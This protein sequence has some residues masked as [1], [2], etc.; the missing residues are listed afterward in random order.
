MDRLRA[1][2][3][4]LMVILSGP[5]L[6]WGHGH[7]WSQATFLLCSAW[8]GAMIIKRAWRPKPVDPDWSPRNLPGIVYIW[9]R[10]RGV[11]YDAN[12]VSRPPDPGVYL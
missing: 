8:A 5:G 7:W 3:F 1:T 11:I 12:K 9:E 2:M 4:G 6:L 10:G